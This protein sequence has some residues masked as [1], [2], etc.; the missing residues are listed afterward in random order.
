M[1]IRMASSNISNSSSLTIST[2]IKFWPE[3]GVS[4][5]VANSAILRKWPKTVASLIQ[6]ASPFCAFNSG[7]GK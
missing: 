5:A 2:S 4:F 1:A 3:L 6:A 7:T